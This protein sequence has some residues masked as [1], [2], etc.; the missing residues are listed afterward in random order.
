[1]Y[2]SRTCRSRCTRLDY[3]PSREG[4]CIFFTKRI[5]GVLLEVDYISSAWWAN[6]ECPRTCKSSSCGGPNPAVRVTDVRS[7]GSH[8]HQSHHKRL[9]PTKSEKH[10]DYPKI[11]RNPS[12]TTRSTISSE[13]RMLHL[14]SVAQHPLK[15]Q[16][17]TE[18]NVFSSTLLGIQ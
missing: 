13:R 14:K 2:S 6:P 9:I 16:I 3:T 5:S 7:D 17:H 8:P 10:P 1:M 4:A 15:T 18:K 12:N 11:K